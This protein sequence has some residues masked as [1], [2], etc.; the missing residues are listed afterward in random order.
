MTLWLSRIM[1]WGALATEAIAARDAA[2]ACPAGVWTR[3]VGDRLA[4]IGLHVGFQL[5]IN[6]G[7]FSF[8]MIGYT[9]FLLTA[10][11]WDAVRAAGASGASAS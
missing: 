2:G 7:L 10:A 9:P 5:F 6:L 11:D 8:A 4:I 3:R 1:S